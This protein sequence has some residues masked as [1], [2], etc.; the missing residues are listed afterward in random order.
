MASLTPYAGAGTTGG[1]ALYTDTNN[2]SGFA[3]FKL[4]E[5][6]LVNGFVSYDV[7]KL[8]AA[9]EALR[10]PKRSGSGLSGRRLSNRLG[11]P[12]RSKNI[13][14]RNDLQILECAPENRQPTDSPIVS[15]IA[16]SKN[17]RLHFEPGPFFCGWGRMMKA[18]RREFVKKSLFAGAG[19]SAPMTDFWRWSPIRAGLPPFGRFGGPSLPPHAS[20]GS[21]EPVYLADLD[22]SQPASGLAKTWQPIRWKRYDF[23]TDKVKGGTFVA[24]QNS[25]APT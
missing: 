11:R 16:S 5:G 13:L 17:S 23:E 10:T 19:L 1:G 22:R 21:G 25:G 18:T 14:F 8:L 2:S 3:L 6:T 4:H 20:T 9:I 24:G 15:E 12:K 7:D